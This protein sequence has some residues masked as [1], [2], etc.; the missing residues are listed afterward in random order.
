MPDEDIPI[1]NKL[2]S[3]LIDEIGSRKRKASLEAIQTEM[4][5]EWP[6]LDDV[7]RA[8]VEKVLSHTH[9]NKQSAARVLNV[10]RKT[11][12]RMIKRYGL[13]LLEARIR[14]ASG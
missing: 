10:D 12:D 7:E 9:G 6:T 5:E 11:L 14:G 4:K 13:S 8:Y 2:L 1:L 3:F